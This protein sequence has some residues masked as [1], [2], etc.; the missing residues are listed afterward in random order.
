LHSF[1]HSTGVNSVAFSPDGRYLL[2]GSDDK[3]VRLWDIEKDRQ[4]ALFE[5]HAETVGCVAFSAD[6]RQVY[7]ASYSPLGG[8]DHTL[9]LW[10]VAT[11]KEIGK[12]EVGDEVHRM[13]CAAFS[14]DG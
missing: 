2:S 13:E 3:L 8:S 10:D 9:R 5:G 12:L 1:A 7:S 14:P 6:G 11:R 4:E